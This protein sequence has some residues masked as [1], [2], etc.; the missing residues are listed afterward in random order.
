MNLAWRHIDMED[1]R[2]EETLKATH[3][4]EIFASVVVRP[5]TRRG[6]GGAK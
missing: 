2:L 6:A 3:S 5:V 4:Y 1:S